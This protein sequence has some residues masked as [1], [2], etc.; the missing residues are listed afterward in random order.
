[1]P[2]IKNPQLIN[3]FKTF[4]NV[5]NMEAKLKYKSFSD[6]VTLNNSTEFPSLPAANRF[7]ALANVAENYNEIINNMFTFFNPCTNVR[8]NKTQTNQ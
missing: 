6:I 2:R 8:R 3:K 5:S 1:M 4:H 7:Q